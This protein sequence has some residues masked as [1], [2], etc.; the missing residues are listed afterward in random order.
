RSPAALRPEIHRGLAER[1]TVGLVGAE[2]ASQPGI[3]ALCREIADR[4]GRPSPSSLKA[5]VITP[6]LASA[7][8]AGGNRSVTVAPEAGSERMRRVINKNLTEVEILRA[9]EWLTTGGV[10]AMKLYVMVGLPTETDAD[11][12]GIVDLVAKV[13]AR[14]MGG[15]SPKVGRLLVS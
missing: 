4:G 5:D 14:L 15:G 12:D 1:S 11:V 7:L 2:M 9:A 8:G 6:A 13:R 10:E 3:A